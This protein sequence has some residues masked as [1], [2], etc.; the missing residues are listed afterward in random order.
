M[1]ILSSSCV[2]LH[3]TLSSFLVDENSTTKYF[4]SVDTFLYFDYFLV[5]FMAR[6]DVARIRQ[7]NE[8]NGIKFCFE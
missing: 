6:A 2:L 3:A 8:V 5:T 1:F 7:I 4:F